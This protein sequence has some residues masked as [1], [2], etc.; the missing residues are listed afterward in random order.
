MYFVFSF[1]SHCNSNGYK[2]W[3]NCSIWFFLHRTLT[4]LTIL[5]CPGKSYSIIPIFHFFLLRPSPV[6]TIRSFT[7]GLMAFRFFFML[8][9]LRKALRY[10]YCYPRDTTSWH[11]II[12]VCLFLRSWS[13]ILSGF[14]SRIDI[15]FPSVMMFSLRSGSC[16][17]SCT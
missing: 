8:C 2:C 3:N 11:L 4:A 1:I 16:I 13:S 6:I 14:S 9:V 5:S 15:A 7:A 10:S 12:Y 17:S